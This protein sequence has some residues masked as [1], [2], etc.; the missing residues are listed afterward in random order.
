MR[1]KQKVTRKEIEKSTINI[2]NPI[3]DLN[4]GF[5]SQVNSYNI[6]NSICSVYKFRSLET[7]NSNISNVMNSVP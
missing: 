5:S 3:L 1:T 4:G 6:S 7:S 2:M